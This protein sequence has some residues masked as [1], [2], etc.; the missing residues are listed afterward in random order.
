MQNDAQTIGA[1][2]HI[3]F[4]DV[5]RAWHYSVTVEKASVRLWCHSRVHTGMSK[6]FDMHTVRRHTHAHLDIAVLTE[7]L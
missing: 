2:G 4:N 1:T 3:M 7:I 5:T 6:R